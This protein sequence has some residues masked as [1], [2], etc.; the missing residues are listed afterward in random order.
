MSKERSKQTNQQINKQAKQLTKKQEA[1]LEERHLSL[2]MV[3]IIFLIPLSIV[4]C[5]ILLWL[6]AWSAGHQTH[7]QLILFRA[8]I[9]LLNGHQVEWVTW[10]CSCPTLYLCKAASA[11]SRWTFTSWRSFPESVILSSP[12]LTHTESTFL[13]GGTH[14]IFVPCF[15][16]WRSRKCC[17]AADEMLKSRWLL[18]TQGLH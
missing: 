5:S 7:L 8:L 6:E 16:T 15:L 11:V 1:S 17:S 13:P 3:V 12:S 9:R 10:V 2:T 18:A 14:I 4:R